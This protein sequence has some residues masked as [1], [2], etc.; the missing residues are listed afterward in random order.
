MPWISP[1]RPNGSLSTMK[2]SGANTSAVCR[3]MEARI[4]STSAMSMCRLSEEYS[5]LRSLMT[6]GTRTKS[7]RVRKSKLPMIGEPDRMSTDSALRRATSE[8]AMVRHRR[9][10]PSPKES[11]L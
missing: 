11:W 2:M 9:R 4:R 6:P 7:T 5:P 3:M 8:C 10:C 1:R